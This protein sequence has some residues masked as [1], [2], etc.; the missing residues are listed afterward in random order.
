[1][2]VTALVIGFVGSLH[3]LVMCS[4]LAMAVT[5]LRS[6]FFLN[7][8][9]YN[10]GRILCYGFL[11]GVS[12][13]F[14]SLFK[15]SGIQHVLTLILGCL[16]MVAGLAGTRYVRVPFLSPMIQ[17]ITSSIKGLFSEFLQRKT[18]LALAMLG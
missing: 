16:L 10:G 1:M 18:T 6:R 5:N 11:G 13:S 8:V 7:R 12:S 9:I 15:L 2:W 17:K 4:P 3:C 14:G